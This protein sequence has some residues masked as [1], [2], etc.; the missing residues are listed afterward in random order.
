MVVAV[1]PQ[2]VA[3]SNAASAWDSR[4]FV[5]SGVDRL[6]L[7]ERAIALAAFVERNPSASEGD[8]AATL[9]AEFAPH[10]SRL[11]IVATSQADLLKKLHRVTDRLGDAKVSFIRDANGIYYTEKPL[12][13]TGSLALLFPGEGAQYLN[14]L[15]DL[16]AVFPEVAETFAW[17]DRVAIEAGRP[18]QSVTRLIHL[19][20]DASPEQTA[21]AESELRR[22]GP[23]IFAVLLADQA[24]FRV[25]QSLRIPVSAM[26]GHSAGEM[27]AVLAAGVMGT[28]GTL[29]P[30]STEIVEIMQRQEDEAGGPEVALLA[31]G[32]GKATVVQVAEAVAGGAVIVAM[33]NC[34]HQCVAVGPTHLVA[35]VE[36]ALT[37]KGMICERLPF[38]RPYHTPFFEPWMGPFRELYASIPFGPPHTP[39]Y[40]CSTGEKFPADPDAIRDLTVN[41]WVNP[42]EFTR[43]VRTMHAD[44]IRLFVEVGPRGNLSAFT[45]DVLRGEAFAAIP[46]N[47]LRKSGPTQINHMVAQLVAHHV[48]LDLGCLFTDSQPIIQWQPAP[49]RL[50][51]DQ[52][53]AALPPS[54]APDDTVIGNYLGVME[55]FLDVQRSVMEA[56]FR[57]AIPTDA[58]PAIDES[59]APVYAAANEPAASPP[60]ALV[61]SI[62]QFQ[63]GEAVIFRRTLDEK[64]DLYADDHTLGGRGVSRVDPK[65]NGL[66]ILPMTFS[67]EAMSEAAALLAPGKVVVAIRNIRLY[68]WVPFDPEP[69]TL[70]VRATI[71]SHDPQTGTIEVKANVRDLGNTFLRDAADKA[72]CE[73]TVVMADHYPEPPAPNPFTLTDEVRCRST[74][75][76]LRRNMFHGPLFQ[77]IRSLD[78]VGKEGIEGTLEVQPR[79][80]WFRSN[81]APHIAIDPVLMDAA[82][83][84]LGAWHLEQPDWSGRILLP[85]GVNA[86]EFFGPTPAVGSTLMVRGHNEEETARQVRHGLEVFD[87][88]GRPW[89]RLT[90][91]GYWRFY[92]PFGEVNFFGPKDNYFLSHAFTDATAGHETGAR[93]Y[94]LD[95]PLDL[96]QPVLRAS[97]I[98]VS[99]T[100]SEIGLFNKLATTGSDQQMGDWFFSRLV[101][102]DAVRGAWWQKHQEPMFPSDMETEQG[103][104]NRF[105]I[106]PRGEPK[107]E[108]FPPVTVTVV[109][110]KVAAF[111]AFAKHIGVGLVLLPKKAKPAQEQEARRRAA[112]LAVADALRVP[113]EQLQITERGSGHFAVSLT[114]EAAA[115]YPELASRSLRV[116]TGREKDAIVATTL[117]EPE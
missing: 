84:I 40:C 11:A 37:E 108:A 111:S 48:P 116:R 28:E 50:P 73:A 33:D 21:A 110:H 53:L 16:R 52:P 68:R 51:Q 70:E 12:Y 38:R 23:S 105:V 44:G 109:E 18:E 87:T 42:V 72:S 76:D 32:A 27:A 117:C 107:T 106:R 57:G 69:T 20:P 7:R 98:R 82:M 35:A 56:F 58:L 4:V 47:V 102:K 46:A 34:P 10:G 15:G 64:E 99:M 26:A 114:R 6:Q 2:L 101:A 86:V 55:Q 5:L 104:G 61:G 49:A 95:P 14:M 78:R 79:D 59:L 75:E 41:H 71:A 88:A 113:F 3:R 17:A 31:V 103:E 115:Q 25:I 91:A 13:A 36:T 93:C 112:G 54:H 67:L 74:V 24:L 8:L 96:R 63:P 89:L 65:Q 30:K 90:G 19:P 80:G 97:G 1:T 66:P 60:F 77:M 9:A 85:I 94:F 83:H 62:E 92:L 39:I 43:M 29:A 22:L 100:P 81:P 45:E